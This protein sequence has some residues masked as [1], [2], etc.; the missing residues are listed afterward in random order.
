MP[1]PASITFGQ[2][3]LTV[4]EIALLATWIWV[5]ISVITDVYRS[6]DLSSAAK[7]GWIFM[8]VLIPLVG[9]MLY[10]IARGDK[11]SEHQVGGER[12]LEDLRDRGILTDE[13]VRRATERRT[14]KTS[15]S[16]AD[17]IAA[18]AD[19]REHG[20]LNDEEFQRAK[21]KAAA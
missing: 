11:M 6:P 16:R 10:V 21:E 17:D 12:Q 7:A 5:A 20:V 1:S 3:L 8:V 18:L 14:R 2:L 15:A 9:V 4:L 19:L 13:E